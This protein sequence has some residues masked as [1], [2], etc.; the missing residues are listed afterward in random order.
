LT[1]AIKTVALRKTFGAVAALEGLDVEVAEGELFG[2]VGPDGA[3]KTTTLRLLSGV[4]APS[5]GEARVLGRDVAREPEAVKEQIAYMSQRFGLYP[6]LTVS[7][8][9][10]FYADLYGV[11]RAERPSR[12]RRLLAFSRMAPFQDRL[13]GQLS[14]GMKQKLGLMCALI[15]RPRLLL[16][17]EPTGGVD[18]VS[19][20]DFWR[21]LYELLREQVTVFVATA[22]LDEAERCNRVG[23]LHAGRLLA[24]AGPA[25]VRG[26]VRGQILE[27]RADDPRRA[28][29]ILRAKL[30]P[31]DVSLFGDRVHVLA[32]DAGRREQLSAILSEAGLAGAEVRAVAPSL[33]DVFV[34]ALPRG[35]DGGHERKG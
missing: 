8:N 6:D 2:L 29:Q 4:L 24:C 5:A 32:P 7:E 10:E 12:L 17:D 14:G 26:L 11:P 23:L 16:L 15:H 34:S 25:E 22:Y 1:P 13:A 20:R 30:G 35:G 28:A 9:M 33:E 27:V 31:D 18:P 21:M 3:G 19:R